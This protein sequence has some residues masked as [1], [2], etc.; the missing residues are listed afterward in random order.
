MSERRTRLERLEAAQAALDARSADPDAN[1]PDE[2]AAGLPAHYL[3]INHI[4]GDTATL[5][6]LGALGIA[7][8]ANFVRKTKAGFARLYPDVLPAAGSNTEEPNA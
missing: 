4:D 1:T 6:A 5:E 8:P 2:V 7:D 3:A